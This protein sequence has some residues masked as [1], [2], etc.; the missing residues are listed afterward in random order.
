MY[1][2]SRESFIRKLKNYWTLWSDIYLYIQICEL[3]TQ[4]FL[5]VYNEKGCWA[6]FMF[7]I[8]IMCYN[9]TMP[10]RVTTNLERKKWKKEKAIGEPMMRWSKTMCLGS[11]EVIQ[12]I[13]ICRDLDKAQNFQ[14]DSTSIAQGTG[15]VRWAQCLTRIVA[16]TYISWEV[17]SRRVS[18]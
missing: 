5:N 4:I 14:S 9:S 18:Q 13:M 10:R 8:C 17:S 7:W 6:R 12:R 1:V 11:L 2:P 15:I 3:G 16:S